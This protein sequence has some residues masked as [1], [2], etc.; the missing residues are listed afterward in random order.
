MPPSEIKLHGLAAGCLADDSLM[1]SRTI[2]SHAND[3]INPNPEIPIFVNSLMSDPPYLHHNKTA[4]AFNNST[5]YR[6]LY[7]YHQLTFCTLHLQVP[8]CVNTTSKPP[9]ILP[10][11]GE[12]EREMEQDILNGKYMNEKVVKR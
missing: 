4:G 6:Y 8:G 9:T 11:F 2:K 12:R 5:L 3:V 1:G 10:H 7:F